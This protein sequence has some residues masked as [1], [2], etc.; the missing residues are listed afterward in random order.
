MKFTYTPP[1]DQEQIQRISAGIYTAQCLSVT[2]GES[3]NGNRQVT[4]ECKV[5]SMRLQF[6]LVLMSTTAWKIKQTRQAFGF[7]D[8]EGAS[9]SFDTAEFIGKTALCL[10]GYGEKLAKSGDP[11]LDI[12]EFIEPN[13][14]IVAQDK[15]ARIIAAENARKKAALALDKADVIPF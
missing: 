2:D 14:E 5:E 8:T 7:S 11:Y 9:V 4:F 12:I 13:K 10:V 3:R 1:G 6:R 15:L